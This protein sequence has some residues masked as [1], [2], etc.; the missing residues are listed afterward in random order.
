MTHIIDS[1]ISWLAPISEGKSKKIEIG[2]ICK[3]SYFW[4]D[5]CVTAEVTVVA[6]DGN[7]G[8]LVPSRNEKKTPGN[9]S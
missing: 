6:D 1:S 3:M 5:K 4:L 8:F 7:L 2:E 9:M